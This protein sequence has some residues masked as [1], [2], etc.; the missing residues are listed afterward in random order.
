V[1]GK[2]GLECLRVR[3]LDADAPRRVHGAD[4]VVPAERLDEAG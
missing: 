1:R 2:Y 4:Q 3:L